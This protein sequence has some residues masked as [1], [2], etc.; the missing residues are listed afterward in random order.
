MIGLRYL[1]YGSIGFV[2]GHV[3]IHG[4]DDQGSQYDLNGNLVDWWQP[5]TKN[6]YLQKIMCIIEQY[7]NYT[8]PLTGLNVCN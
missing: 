8:E 6:H 1:N 5:I 7:G 2:M 3:I 4:F